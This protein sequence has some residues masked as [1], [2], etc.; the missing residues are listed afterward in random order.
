MSERQQ[1]E[2][3]LEQIEGKDLAI[4]LQYTAKV[5]R[6]NSL[7]LTAGVPLDISQSG[8]D[9]ILDRM[10]D[11]IDRQNVRYQLQALQ[12]DIDFAKKEIEVNLQQQAA[13]RSAA[14]AAWSASE[15]RGPYKESDRTTKE[16]SNFEGTRKS[17]MNRIE[18]NLAMI[19]AVKAKLAA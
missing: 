12:D 7:V 8:L 6:E 3:Q 18:R 9:R 2:K 10:A 14:E 1:S 4:G 11:A 19:D 16:L 15:R 5:G 13:A 17:L